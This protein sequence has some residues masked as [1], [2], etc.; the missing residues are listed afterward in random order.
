LD[1]EL[2]EMLDYPSWRWGLALIALTIAIH[3]AV[4]MMGSAAVK[5]RLRLETRVFDCGT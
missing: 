4:V 1:G 2:I 3:A 5:I